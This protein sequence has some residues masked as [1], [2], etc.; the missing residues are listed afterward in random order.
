VVKTRGRRR[1]IQGLSGA[2]ALGGVPQAFAQAPPKLS[3]DEAGERQRRLSAALRALNEQ[4]G[5]GVSAQDFDLAEA[6]ATGALLEADARLRPLVL[7]E[8]LDVPVVFRARR[9]R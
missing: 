9:R 8:D 4:G 7:P 3:M 1:F 5:L 2:A 6:Y